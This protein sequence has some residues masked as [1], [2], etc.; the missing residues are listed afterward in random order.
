MVAQY[1]YISYRSYIGIQLSYVRYRRTDIAYGSVV[2]ICNAVTALR[3]LIDSLF[4]CRHLGSTPHRKHLWPTM[5]DNTK[6]RRV[7]KA[8][9]R[10]ISKGI[11]KV[12]VKLNTERAEEDIREVV[13]Q[14]REQPQPALAVQAYLA[15]GVVSEEDISPRDRPVAGAAFDGLRQ[16]LGW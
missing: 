12:Q 9:E 3:F 15:M 10:N 8:T 16:Q 7:T 5:A 14:L 2:R 13:G 1:L 6:R 11:T 4:E